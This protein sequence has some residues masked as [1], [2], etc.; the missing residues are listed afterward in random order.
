MGSLRCMGGMTKAF[1]ANLGNNANPASSEELAREWGRLAHYLKTAASELSRWLALRRMK[2]LWEQLHPETRWGAAPGTRDRILGSLVPAFVDQAAIDTGFSRSTIS[3]WIRYAEDL[4]AL[5]GESALN[6][7]VTCSSRLANNPK[8]ILVQLS[9]LRTREWAEDVVVIYQ[10]GAGEAKA[11]EALATYLG[12]QEERPRRPGGE[13]AVIQSEDRAGHVDA[14]KNTK[15]IKAPKPKAKS[16][17]LNLPGSIGVELNGK[18]VII[19]LEQIRKNEL[20]VS[21]PESAFTLTLNGKRR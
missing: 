12:V 20:L 10:E 19:S 16:Y 18:K 14:E 1:N 6:R 5:L 9:Q 15:G 7:L 8:G 11:R 17:G 21:W 3:R 4:V 2:L 13:H